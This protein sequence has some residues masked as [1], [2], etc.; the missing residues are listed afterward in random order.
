M[1]Q[2]RFQAWIATPLAACLLLATTSSMAADSPA[3]TSGDNSNEPRTSAS[4]KIDIEKLRKQI[5]EQQK[6]IAAMQKMLAEQQRL[7]D[8]A[9]EQPAEVAVQPRLVRAPLGEVAST[10]PM[11]PAAPVPM[12]Q[13]LA[14][15]S[16][17][18]ASP[19]QFGIGNTT[20]L[21]VGF[22][23]ATAVWRDK[24]AG[25]S[26]GANFGSIPFN[27]VPA[28][29]LSEFRFSP[30]NSRIGFRVDGD[31]KGAHFIGYNEMDF[32]GTSGSNAIGVSNGAFVPRLRLFWIDVRKD[33]WEVL[34][35]QSWSMMTPN[36]KGI[37]ALPADIF[38][39][40]V[41]DVNYMI[42]LPWARTAGARLLYHPDNKVTFGLSLENPDQYI[43]GSGGGPTIV[44]PAA[45]ASLA[46]GQFDNATNVLS[47]PNMNPDIIAKLAFDPSS[48]VHVEIA[49]I[50]RT[51]KDW[52]PVSSVHSTKAG[53][54]GSINASLEV[55]KNFR[56]ITTNYW[57]DGGGRYLFGN[58]PDVVIRADGS[59][60]PIHSGGTVDGFEAQ[61]SKNLL[62]YAY[63]GGIYIGRDVA[64]DANGSLVGYGYTKS[65]NS[66]NRT[67]QEG[68]FGFN[69]TIWKDA[70]YGAINFMGQYQYLNRDPWYVAVGAPKSAHDNTIYFNLRY[71]LPG[72]APTMGK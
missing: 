68:T 70:K 57:S 39:S 60:S 42:G 1:S 71:T 31:W 2:H 36:R 43:G 27:N 49:G 17:E 20:I 16:P 72:S 25:S 50:E 52:N 8:A 61:V 32:L 26:I 21:P 66:Q 15:S 13:P 64:V 63:Y 34:A 11:I 24:D 41:I 30:Q 44:L 65:A 62:L 35:G 47:T 48:R 38:Y 69:Q 67:V 10:S 46:G 19:L 56:L 40:Q 22:M 59:I 4:Q 29:H 54:A 33:K 6:Q 28:A 18:K 53:G 37:S 55:V 14:S 7:L 51:F 58:A 5:A 45:L 12:D 9:S 23:D 3:A